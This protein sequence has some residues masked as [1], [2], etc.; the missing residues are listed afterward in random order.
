MKI[1][2]SFDTSI[3]IPVSVVTKEPKT[4]VLLS[5]P[6]AKFMTESQKN[7]DSKPL[8]ILDSEDKDA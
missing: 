2:V 7:T 8:D 1:T 5:S 6:A 4:S 3:L